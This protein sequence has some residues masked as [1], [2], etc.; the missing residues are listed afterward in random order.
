MK[1]IKIYSRAIIFFFYLKYFTF[2]TSFSFQSNDL[3]GW[4]HDGR[5]STDGPPDRIGGVRHVNDDNLC[6]LTNLLSDTDELVRLHR[7]CVE[8]YRGWIDADI[9]E[10]EQLY[11]N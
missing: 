2:N 5:V 4:V 8:G 3:A 11:S 10:L 6:S 7:E 1:L 9:C